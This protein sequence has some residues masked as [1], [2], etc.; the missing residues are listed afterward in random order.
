MPE[1]NFASTEHELIQEITAPFSPVAEEG[2]PELKDPDFPVVLRGYDRLAVD[3]YVKQARETI[4]ELR[5]TSSPDAA[6]RRAL[7]RVGEQVSGILQRA[8]ETADKITANA[9]SEAQ[10]RLDGA[11]AEAAEVTAQAQGEL[12]R[13]RRDG[14]EIRAKAER[15][16]SEL[17]ADTDR[18]W[19]ER[20]RI[21][22]D[23]RQ[24]AGELM[25]LADAASERFP[26]A[27]DT[28]TGEPVAPPELRHQTGEGAI[29]AEPEAAEEQAGSE[30]AT[31][32]VPRPEQ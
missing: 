22:E 3:A 6:V 15:Q 29:S 30:D 12:E 5:S 14:Q 25:E 31:Q 28:A 26:P 27:E 4:E 8:H 23:A 32:V 7:E 11:R 10:A 19:A 20:H 17:D 1:E 21:V 24:L 13:A 16:L 9:R 2:A 18:I